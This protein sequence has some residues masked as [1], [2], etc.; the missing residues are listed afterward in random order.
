MAIIP[1]TLYPTKIDTTDPAY[2]LGKAQNISAP[3]AG[4]G[5]P[6]DKDWLN[7]LWGFL[8]D[9]LDQG[10]I[11]AS[12][13][14]DKVGTS[15]YMDAFKAIFEPVFSK[16]TAFNKS[17][18][19]TTADILQIGATIVASRVLESDGTGKV[20][21]AAKGTAYNKNFG[22]TAG[23]V[24]AGDDARFGTSTSGLNVNNL[25]YIEDQQASGVGAGACVA[26][27]QNIRALNTKVVDNIVGAS[28]GTNQITL[29]AGTYFVMFDAPAHSSTTAIAHK[30]RLRNITDASN[31]VVGTS[32]YVDG[33]TSFQNTGD[34]RAFGTGLFTIAGAKV[35]E[36][37]HY[38]SG[39]DANGLGLA[40]SSGD[41][42]VY[43]RIAIYK[44]G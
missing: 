34:N 21:S 43:A 19:L 17:F 29:P 37:Q 41:I 22:T 44:V 35:F 40:V 24:A 7:D 9:L 2:P 23:T 4:D 28:L 42:E 36:L 1:L 20:I 18:G 11:T 3:A 6:N 5:T 15:D 16:N 12:G 10:S 39:A 13:V 25:L 31:A 27:T 33:D 38:T 8:Q 32:D 30:L 14:P 26:A